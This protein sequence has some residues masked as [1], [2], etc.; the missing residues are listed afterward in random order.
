M[1]DEFLHSRPDFED[2]IRITGD[3]QGIDPV[4]VE[5]DYWIMHCLFGLQQLGLS[6]ELKGGTSLSKGFGI[7]DR[8]SEDIDIRIEPPKEL[9]VSTGRN[10]SKP[11]HIESRRNFYDWLAGHIQIDGIVGVERDPAFD[12]E[13]QYRSG[14]IRLFYASRIGMLE[15][16]KDGILLEVG[17]DTVA[18]NTPRTITSWAYERGAGSGDFIDNRAVNV[19]CYHPGHTFV[20]KLQTLSTKFRRQQ[21]ESAFPA[22][23]MRHY[24]DVY[25]L[26]KEPSVI[27]FV[28]TPEYTS[29]KA[30]RFRAG[31]SPV[32][33]ENEAFHLR[34]PGVRKLYRDAYVSSRTLYYRGQ[35]D[36]DEVIDTISRA[37]C[38]EGF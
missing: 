22:N 19:A 7:I 36:F 14:G 37:V 6:F 13:A 26:L 25:Q 24:Y 29:H 11:A 5:K 28:G 15:G 12:D 38:G 21:A 1:P 16:I 17:F 2:L 8:F 31:D 32:L 10:H 4:L 35:P 30:T 18:P 27:E 3:E 33:A 9:A 34:E 23:F 20:E